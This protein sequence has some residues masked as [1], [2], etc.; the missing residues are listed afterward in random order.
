[1][2]EADHHPIG[3]YLGMKAPDELRAECLRTMSALSRQ[4]RNERR[5]DR[6]INS[7][8]NK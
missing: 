8:Q 5:C 3:E 4:Y 2:T 1:M 7:Q 6:G